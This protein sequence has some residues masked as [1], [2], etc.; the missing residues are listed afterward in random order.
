MVDL[1]RPSPHDIW[2][3]SPPSSTAVVSRHHVRV[4][5]TAVLDWLAAVWKLVSYW[6]MTVCC[7]KARPVLDDDNQRGVSKLSIWSNRIALE[8]LRKW[9]A[10]Y[11]WKIKTWCASYNWKRKSLWNTD[12][13]LRSKRPVKTNL[14]VY[15]CYSPTQRNSIKLKPGWSNYI[16]GWGHPPPPPTRNFQGPW[17]FQGNLIW[18]WQKYFRKKNGVKDPLLIFFF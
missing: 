2:R 6:M 15:F 10:S 9:C 3:I 13:P 18:P 16:I 12:W 14:I 4:I 5:Y 1:F 11:N 7:L 17:N 8:A